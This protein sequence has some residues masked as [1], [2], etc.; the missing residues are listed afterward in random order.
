LDANRDGKLSLHELRTAWS[1]LER[2]GG[3]KKGFITRTQIPQQFEIVVMEGTAQNLVNFLIS[4]SMSV[5]KP[6][7]TSASDNLPTWFRK[8]DT[9]GDGFISPREFLGSRADFERIDIN[10]DGLID[11]DE[12]RHFDA[13]VRG[14]K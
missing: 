8:M 10:H 7:T 5:N 14:K 1:R 11:P 3:E 13:L 6:V 12:A 2:L 9:N 4:G